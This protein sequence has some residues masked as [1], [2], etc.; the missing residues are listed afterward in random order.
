[1]AP[2]FW[3]GR[4]VSVGR[5]VRQPHALDGRAFRQPQGN[6]LVGKRQPMRQVSI[7]AGGLDV[8]RPA[9]RRAGTEIQIDQRQVDLRAMIDLSTR[10]LGGATH[11]MPK[12]LLLRPLGG[13]LERIERLI[14][15]LLV[16]GRR[17]GDPIDGI[18]FVGQR[19]SDVGDHAVFG[20]RVFQGDRFG[21]LGRKI[22]NRRTPQL[23]RVGRDVLL[24]VGKRAV[25]V[26]EQFQ[27][28]APRRGGSR[29]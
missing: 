8:E 26:E 14:L 23:K 20:G 22:D 1:M 2:C 11:R 16:V 9:G 29:G 7:Q 5:P 6:S 18:D 17:G 10:P 28:V 24:Q 19:A 3:A 27:L 21:P 12:R 13:V 15:D 25:E 4:K